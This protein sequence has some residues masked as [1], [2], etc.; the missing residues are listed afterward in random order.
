MKILAVGDVHWSRFSSIVRR[1]GDKYSVRLE[2]LI[3]SVNWAENLAE[4]KDCD[5]IVYLGDFFDKAECNAMEI[6]A[7]QEINWA[8]KEHIFLVGNHEAGNASLEFNTA[9][10]FGL[11]TFNV[12]KDI[13][14]LHVDDFHRLVFLPYI[15][16]RNRKPLSECVEKFPGHTIIFSHNDI[17]GFAMGRF[18]SQEGFE[19]TDIDANCDLY[20]N[21]HLHNG[22]K[23]TDKIINI[24]NLTGQN[25]SEDATKYDHHVFVID[26][27]SN[28]IEVY[29]NPYALNFYQ[30]DFTGPK[31]ATTVDNMSWIKNNAVMTV[32]CFENDEPYLRNTL[33]Q[34]SVTDM[35]FILKNLYFHEQENSTD[36]SLS[37]DHL[38]RFRQYMRETIGGSDVLE[39]ELAEV[40]K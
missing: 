8:N 6:T 39:K 29:E 4:E 5:I 23:I 28:G 26:T 1:M 38:E 40:C 2:N 22:G 11:A 24:G 18:I 15:L 20:I 27:G 9:D 16:E 17:K 19:L 13:E 37:V 25:F 35:R 33:T 32:K 10:L 3:K 34:R 31:G 7:L 21:G 12:I 30:L 36:D 14:V